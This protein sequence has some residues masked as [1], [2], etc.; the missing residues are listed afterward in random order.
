MLGEGAQRANRPALPDPSSDLVLGDLAAQR[1]PVDAERVGGFRQAAVAAR[2]AAAKASR[3]AA[4]EEARKAALAAEAAA[5]AK[6][7]ATVAKL[8][9]VAPP[10]VE[11][12]P[13]VLAAIYDEFF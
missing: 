13:A 2:E 11:I 6:A 12:D 5:A 9:D 8:M 10:V 4:K 1:V 7:A 3:E